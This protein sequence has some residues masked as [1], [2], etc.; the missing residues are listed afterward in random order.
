MSLFKEQETKLVYAVKCVHQPRTSLREEAK[1]RELLVPH[2]KNRLPEVLGFSEIEEWETMVTLCGGKET[3][4]ELIMKGSMPHTQM[5]SVWSEAV[6]ELI[7]LWQQT[8]RTYV[9]ENDPRNLCTRFRRIADGLIAYARKDIRLADVIDLPVMIDGKHYPS[10]STALAEAYQVRP[11]L[12]SVMCHGDFQPSNIIV[13]RDG[14]W[15]LVDWEWA[16]EG[17]DWRNG[18]SHM[19]GWWTSRHL[20]LMNESSWERRQGSLH[21]STSGFIPRHLRPYIDA[22]SR[23]F[24]AQSTTSMRSQDCSDIQKYLALLY[25][26]QIRF[27]PIWG[28]ESFGIELLA[29][30]LKALYPSEGQSF[31][32]GRCY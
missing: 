17:H 2:L 26:G 23:L 24:K 3:L 20:Q 28:R 15:W 1:R 18:F 9:A 19:F 11:P 30:A 6:G 8:K 25:F 12:F 22:V 31:F 29:C 5:L 21:L 32:S 10:I 16:G 27:L 7:C 13:N 14:R 4:H